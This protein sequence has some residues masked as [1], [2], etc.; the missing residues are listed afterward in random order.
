GKPILR[1]VPSDLVEDQ[2][3]RLFAAYLQRRVQDESFMRFC[4]RTPDADLIS[5][6]NGTPGGAAAAA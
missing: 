4:V 5:I 1:R 3:T 6:A 2:V